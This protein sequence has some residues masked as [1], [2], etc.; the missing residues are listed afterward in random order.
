MQRYKNSLSF[1]TNRYRVSC[2]DLELII[3][4]AFLGKD[5]LK[6]S[7]RDTGMPNTNSTGTSER[8]SNIKQFQALIEWFTFSFAPP[9]VKAGGV[10]STLTLCHWNLTFQSLLFYSHMFI[11]RDQ[12]LP[13]IAQSLQGH[14]LISCYGQFKLPVKQALSLPIACLILTTIS[15]PR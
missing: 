5:T 7:N 15:H 1:Q 3:I 4:L 8:P 13:E 12:S 9:A 10:Q 11:H 6:R 14:S 2:I